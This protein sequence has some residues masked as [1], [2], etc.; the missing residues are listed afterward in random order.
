MQELEDAK[1][2]FIEFV[3]RTQTR[4]K[5]LRAQAHKLQTS[6]DWEQKAIGIELEL[7]MQA[8]STE[9]I[10]TQQEIDDLIAN[11]KQADLAGF[12][13]ISH[14]FTQAVSNSYAPKTDHAKQAGLLQNLANT[15][16]DI[17]D[18]TQ[19]EVGSMTKTF[20]DLRYKVQE[21]LGDNLQS[22]KNMQESAS[23][24]AKQQ[25]SFLFM[26]SPEQNPP[27][28]SK[29]AALVLR[30]LKGIE[31]PS[32]NK[33]MQSFID[34]KYAK[35]ATVVNSEEMKLRYTQ[36]KQLIAAK[37]RPEYKRA[38]TKQQTAAAL[39]NEQ[40]AFKAINAAMDS[41][42]NSLLKQVHMRALTNDYLVKLSQQKQDIAKN[43]R[44][45]NE[46]ELKEIN[47]NIKNLE[48]SIAKA[49]NIEAMHESSMRLDKIIS[50]SNS[51]VRQLQRA[52][53]SLP[54]IL[55]KFA[56]NIVQYVGNAF[57]SSKEPA[58]AV[59]TDN[60][61][62]QECKRDIAAGAS[63][64]STSDMAKRL[65]AD[66]SALRQ[67]AESKPVA[68]AS[69]ETATKETPDIAPTLEEDEPSPSRPGFGR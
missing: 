10:G 2:S 40:A 25:Q 64:S 69:K 6:S 28:V 63:K 9:I 51:T 53:Y 42:I 46:A 20:E 47:T 65:H 58:T 26:I 45:F 3:H 30:E 4:P 62:W 18:F 41:A 21:N 7:A 34:Q 52:V 56:A 17:Q 11:V 48:D 5:Q 27:I 43:Q 61:H 38:V 39:K 49:D 32:H 19:P 13:N 29:K 23:N 37:S 54:A 67:F 44:L 60:K 14:K 66:P 22:C 57:S 12:A 35:L 1:K 16:L 36:Y 8:P 59:T 68:V 50:D 31:V 33:N 15:G 24:L 55:Y